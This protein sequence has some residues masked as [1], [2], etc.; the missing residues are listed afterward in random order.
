M[1]DD[2]LDFPVKMQ[3]F[4]GSL[5]QYHENIARENFFGNERALARVLAFLPET[6]PV[7]FNSVWDGQGNLKNIMSS[8]GYE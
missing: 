2:L 7:D 5:G 8:H 3:E 1:C 4:L 6:N